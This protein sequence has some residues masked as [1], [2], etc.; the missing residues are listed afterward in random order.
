MAAATK[1]NY[2][3]D[4]PIGAFQ[5]T[6]N[7][8]V[9]IFATMRRGGRSVYAFDVSDP[10]KPTLEW[11]INQTTTN[12]TNLGQTWSTPRVALVKSLPTAPVLIMG[13][14]F[15]NV[16][17]DDTPTSTSIG[18]GVYI[19][20]MANGAR[21]KYLDTDHSVP[22]DVSFLDTDGDGFVDRG[23]VVDVRANLYRIDMEKA[24]GTALAPAAWEIT[25][26][27]NFNDAS[28]KRR[29][30]FAP[31]V[32]R[33]KNYTAL[34]LGTGDREKPLTGTTCSS[35]PATCTN[36]RFFIFKDRN[37]AKGKPASV[38]VLT[39]P[40]TSKVKAVGDDASRTDPDA[41]Y[42]QMAI[43][44]E[45]VINQPVTFGGVTYFSTSRP[46]SGGQSCSTIISKAYQVPLICRAP[47][48]SELVGDGLPPSPVV[49]YVEVGN[50]KV[51]PFVI[52]GPNTKKSAIEVARP[53]LSVP[54]NRKRSY[55]FMQN[56][57]R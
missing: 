12:Y 30:F 5:N 17:E 15:D 44:G 38:T 35:D 56:Q 48:V 6:T 49:G 11:R 29:V 9:M 57:D 19:I 33:T 50:G 31:D 16:A 27:A 10:V 23:Y 28:G 4:G 20:D 21:L 14:G 34:M 52:G 46:A 40:D 3:F 51:V 43:N 24:D 18:K 37:V 54:G 47:T 42:V 41:C 13:G 32:V 45:K 7:G 39:E 36:D 55:W 53:N 22:S 8:K 2:Y 25:K 26:L 1:R